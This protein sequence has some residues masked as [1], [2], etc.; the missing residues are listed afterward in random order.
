MFCPVLDLKRV[1]FF[2]A[3]GMTTYSYGI[4]G[5]K[6]ASYSLEGYPN[7]NRFRTPSRLMVLMDYAGNTS[8]INMWSGYVGS[9]ATKRTSPHAD[10]SNIL[11]A[12]SHA[13]LLHQSEESAEMW[14][15]EGP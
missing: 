14:Q 4:M 1:G 3:E 11:F 6:G 7:T 13:K 9:D 8:G 2:W 15:S 12:D 10:R 5:K